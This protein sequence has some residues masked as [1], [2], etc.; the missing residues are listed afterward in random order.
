MGEA[1]ESSAEVCSVAPPCGVLTRAWLGLGQGLGL[2]LGLGLALA[3]ALALGL[4]LLG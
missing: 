4:G 1:K 3:L 2:G